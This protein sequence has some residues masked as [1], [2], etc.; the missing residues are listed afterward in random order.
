MFEELKEI[1]KRPEPFEFYTAEELWTDVH[2]ARRM[3]EYH[4]NE[5][6]DAA[7]RNREFI[8]KSAKWIIEN[9]NLSKDSSVID[10][11]C[12]P[13]LY[14]LRFAKTGATVTG[15]DFSENSLSYAK[16]EAKKNQ[17]TIDY[18]YDN[19][20]NYA[21]T[22]KFDL[23]TMIMCD[24]T[25]LG[26]LQRKNL[27]EKF[28]RL[29][30][31]NGAIL[32]DVYSLGYFNKK[33]EQAVFEFNQMDNFWSNKD[34]YCFL[35]TF[36]YEEEKVLLD[37]YTIIT[38][39]EKR[40]IYNWAQCFSKEMIVEEFLKAGFRIEKFYAD[41]SGKEYDDNSNEFAI[42]VKRIK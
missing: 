11:G 3:L 32:L 19:Y 5:L 10:F 7:S 31:P 9:F 29:L 18:V 26:T 14:T 34:Y 35:N 22:Q 38:K 8:D 12:G 6:V 15:V 41:V 25:A 2:I 13:G 16:E 24:F 1:N 42:V 23:I 39:T 27:L 30:K 28:Y 17:L 21:T 40:Q 4:L 36:K 20:L 33:Q 37:K